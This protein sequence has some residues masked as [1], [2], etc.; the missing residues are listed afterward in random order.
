MK[1]IK[2]R[3]CKFSVGNCVTIKDNKFTLMKGVVT[4]VSFVSFPTLSF[5]TRP[6][7]EGVWVIDTNP[8]YY[9]SNRDKKDKGNGMGMMTYLE[10]DLELDLEENRDIKLND[11]GI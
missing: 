3:P 10:E 11:L 2:M 9:Y 6:I 5:P 1:K 7:D 8:S 4:G